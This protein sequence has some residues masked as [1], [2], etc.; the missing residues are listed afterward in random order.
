MVIPKWYSSKPR[1]WPWRKWYSTGEEKVDSENRPPELRCHCGHALFLPILMCNMRTTPSNPFQLGVDQ[2]T[3]AHTDYRAPTKMPSLEEV[4]RQCCLHQAHLSQAPPLQYATACS[5]LKADLY[6]GRLQS[7]T[8]YSQAPRHEHVKDRVE[9][10]TLGIQKGKREKA[11]GGGEEVF[12]R[13]G[14]PAQNHQR[15]CTFSLASLMTE[16]F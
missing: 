2:D 10:I 8:S 16:K 11:G 15:A 9:Q 14:C 6:T 13:K 4:L 12:P 3:V 5:N 1:G 7:L